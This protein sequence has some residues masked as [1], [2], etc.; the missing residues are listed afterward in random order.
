[1]LHKYLYLGD[2][3][4]FLFL[5]FLSCQLLFLNLQKRGTKNLKLCYGFITLKL[6]FLQSTISLFNISN[7]ACVCTEVIPIGIFMK[8]FLHFSLC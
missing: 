2:L 5:P 1:M 6:I 4:Q 7:E 8:H 3:A